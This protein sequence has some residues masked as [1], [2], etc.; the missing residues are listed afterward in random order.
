MPNYSLVLMRMPFTSGGV[1]DGFFHY[2]LLGQRGLTHKPFMSRSRAGK[3]LHH[4][5]G[6]FLLFAG[7]IN[8]SHVLWV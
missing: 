7:V 2:F 5:A 8:L 1:T 3:R 6:S 4:L